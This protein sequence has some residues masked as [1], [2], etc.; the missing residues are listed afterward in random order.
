MAVCGV[1]EQLVDG[2]SQPPPF[3]SRRLRKTE[4]KYSTFDRELLAMHCAICHFWNFMKGRHFMIFAD[5]SHSRLLFQKCPMR[6]LPDSNAN[7]RPFLNVL[8]MFDTLAE[9]NLVAN[10]LSCVFLSAVVSSL[11]NLD[12]VVMAQA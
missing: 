6:G 1:L 2:H 8:Q 3:S 11:N 7:S 4:T 10:T 12:F 5:I 9:S